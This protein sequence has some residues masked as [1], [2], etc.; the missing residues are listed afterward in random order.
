[1]IKIDEVDRS[2]MRILQR[3]AKATIKDIGT[4][5]NLSSTPIF[6]RI[7]KLDSAGVIDRYV[8]II[9]P[10]LI[11]LSLC[12]FIHIS[13]K[14]HSKIAIDTFVEQVTAFGEVLECH[15]ISGKSDFLLKMRHKDIN[16]YNDFVLNKISTVP[17]ISNVETSFSLSVRKDTTE[18]PI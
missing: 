14:D 18:L 12:V 2:I 17:N 8:T 5:L 9:N 10:G 7:K 16:A 6:E 15:H 11:D 1:M 4:E 3:N 13:I